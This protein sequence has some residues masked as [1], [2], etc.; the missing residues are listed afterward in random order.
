MRKKAF[1]GW[2]LAIFLLLA[3]GPLLAENLLMARTRLPFQAALGAVQSAIQA[4]GYRVAEVKNV[5]LGLLMMGY[6]SENYK[7]VFFGKAEEIES[8]SR[9]HPELI[10]YLPLQILVFSEQSD[11]LLVTTDPTYLAVLFPRPELFD[12]FVRWEQ[13][14]QAILETVREA[15]AP[16]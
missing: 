8:L 2:L 14:L 5:D 3:S 11:T 7:V 6:L 9:Q 4:Q 13:D 15:P 1:G 16:R 12:V 10:P